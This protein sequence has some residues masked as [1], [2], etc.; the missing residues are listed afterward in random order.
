MII[1]FQIKGKKAQLIGL[2]LALIVLIVSG[3]ALGKFITAKTGVADLFNS[4]A[5]IL[6]LKQ[7]KEKFEFYARESAILAVAEA[8][9]EIADAGGFTGSDCMVE[10][11]YLK[12][13]DLNPNIN[14]EFSS[15]IEAK[16]NKFVSAYPNTKLDAELNLEFN[17]ITYK[18]STQDKKINLDSE[19]KQLKG[20]AE[21]FFAYSFTYDFL[22]SFSL[23][24]DDLNL[25][26]FKEIKAKAEGCIKLEKTGDIETCMNEL[27]FNSAIKKAES[28]VYFDLISKKR[29]FIGDAYKNIVLKFSY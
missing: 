27:Q 19:K 1:K 3:I 10:S 17:K 20:S 14:E 24:F 22:P 13:C 6:E 23:S 21:G 7:E 12:F 28:K 26:S 11:G 25:N 9:R 8:Y 5:K 2:G 18:V 15:E 29:Y 4:P 16:M